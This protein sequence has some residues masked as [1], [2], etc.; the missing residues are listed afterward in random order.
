MTVV[1][2]IVCWLRLGL[3]RVQLAYVFVY[4]QSLIN[5]LDAGEYRDDI[6]LKTTIMGFI[7]AALRYGAGQVIIV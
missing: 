5:F 4:A 6:T 7:N 3:F 2:Q 1:F